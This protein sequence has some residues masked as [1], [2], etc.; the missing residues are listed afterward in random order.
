MKILIVLQA[1]SSIQAHTELPKD[2]CK[3]RNYRNK[4]SWEHGGFY[5]YEV[6]IRKG[7][8]YNLF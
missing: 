1:L 6:V 8:I 4:E 5:P 3:D 2:I 7:K